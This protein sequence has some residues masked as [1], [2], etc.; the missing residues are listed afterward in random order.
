M[1]VLFLFL[2]ILDNIGDP[3]HRHSLPRSMKFMVFDDKVRFTLVCVCGEKERARERLTFL[4]W[5]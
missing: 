2:F 4:F 5:L 3:K 1:G